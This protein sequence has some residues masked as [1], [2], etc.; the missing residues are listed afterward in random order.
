ML[1]WGGVAVV[2]LALAGLAVYF[3][4]VGLDQAALLANVVSAFIALAGLGMSG[5]GLVLA[6]RSSSMSSPSASAG[7]VQ[8]N[9]VRD[10]GR[11]FAAMDGDI[12]Y[13]GGDVP[14]PAPAHGDD[15]AL[16]DSDEA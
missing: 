16:D 6:R 9:T 1:V 4:V 10:S 7:K 2:V 13:H 12:I 14:S 3:A 15:D 11:L 5:Y 8:V